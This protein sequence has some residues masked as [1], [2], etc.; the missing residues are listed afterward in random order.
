MFLN[1]ICTTWPCWR[2]A[3]WCDGAPPGTLCPRC[4]AAVLLR[5]LLT[6]TPSTDLHHITKHLILFPADRVASQNNH[7]E[8]YTPTLNTS[9]WL[10]KHLHQQLEHFRSFTL[11]SASSGELFNCFA[12]LFDILFD[13]LLIVYALKWKTMHSCHHHNQKHSTFH[14]L[15]YKV[16]GT[17]GVVS[18]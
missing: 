10:S 6:V 4:L 11:C 16:L 5:S 14:L 2:I 9:S 8:D 17:Q 12:T 13:W 15:R 18:W 7:R 1:G 3:G